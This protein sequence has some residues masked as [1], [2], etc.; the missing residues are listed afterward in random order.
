MLIENP[1]EK[2]PLGR[3]AK[4]LKDNTKMDLSEIG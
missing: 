2:R 4:R 3:H 1:L